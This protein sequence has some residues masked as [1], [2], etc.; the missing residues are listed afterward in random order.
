MHIEIKEIHDQ[1][2]KTIF[3]LRRD[4]GLTQEE[5]ALSF[6]CSQAFIDQ[7]ESGEKHLNIE[8]VYKLASIFK[9][10]IRDIFPDVCLKFKGGQS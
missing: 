2:R 10:S 1:I 3:Q 6:N 8:H 9:C 4:Q 7:L 5:V